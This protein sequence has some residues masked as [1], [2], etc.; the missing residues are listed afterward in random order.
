MEDQEKKSVDKSFEEASEEASKKADEKAA[1]KND[2]PVSPRK[3]FFPAPSN[4]KDKIKTAIDKRQ[5]ELIYND[6]VFIEPI[7]PEK[8]EEPRPLVKG[9]VDM[10]FLLWAMILVCFG[11]VMSYSAS[12]V[13]AERY[14]DSSY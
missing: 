6:V 7:T 2:L 11:A 5:E 12:A 9:N 8:P 13:Y 3:S 10:W 1:E 14:Y 4:I